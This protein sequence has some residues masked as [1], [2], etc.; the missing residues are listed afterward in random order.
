MKK[1]ITITVL[2]VLVLVAT[3]IATAANN[4]PGKAAENDSESAS[5]TRYHGNGVWSTT[6]ILRKEDIK[7]D[8]VSKKSAATGPKCYKLMGVKWPSTP[9]YVAENQK[10]LDIAGISISKWDDET[11]FDLLGGGTVDSSA[12]FSDV[13]DGKNSYSFDDYPLSGVIAVCR[14]WWNKNGEIIEYDIMFDEDFDWGNA[15]SSETPVM[16]L[17]NIAT[18]EI[19]HGFGLLDLYMRRCDDQTMYGYSGYG[20]IEKRTL[21]YG[22]ILGIKAI[23]GE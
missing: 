14:T 20:D 4:K 6:H 15:T 11:G 19:G 18:H 10:L 12:G 9:N 7:Q 5:Y 17:Q 16:D 22:D 2:I 23:Y 3:S 8:K 13:R 21:E 1:I